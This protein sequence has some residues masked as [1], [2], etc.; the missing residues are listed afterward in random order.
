MLI[1]GIILAGAIALAF[2]LK[3]LEIKLKCKRKGHSHLNSP[4]RL[5]VN[6]KL[7]MGVAFTLVSITLAIVKLLLHT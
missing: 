1:I 4:Y 6:E 7:T 2:Y 5:K 3:A